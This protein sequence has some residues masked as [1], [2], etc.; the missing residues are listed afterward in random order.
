MIVFTFVV[1]WPHGS[2]MKWGI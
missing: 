2:I 1:K